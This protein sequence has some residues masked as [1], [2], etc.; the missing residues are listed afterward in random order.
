MCP[1]AERRR[2]E[3][4]PV[5]TQLDGRLVRLE[6]LELGHV[7][8]LVAAAGESRQ[9]YAFSWVPVGADAM[10]AYVEEALATPDHLAFATRQR[11]D[12]RIVG[13]TR[14]HQVTPW[15]W[16]PGHPL[17]RTDR[18]DVVEIGHTWLAASAQR[19]GINSEAKL[20]MLSQAFDVWDVHAVHI[21]TDHRNDRSRRA[22]ERLGATLDGI[23][24]ADRPGADG[25]VRDSALY[26]MTRTEWP[27]AKQR[28]EERIYNRSTM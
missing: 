8:A 15:T 14:Y 7:P 10:R 9:T 28:L 25:T 3:L 2:I 22:I 13:S 1:V 24:R 26:S 4:G 20:L 11:A 17:Q 23:R 5:L 21:S 6:R 27:A 16:P 18:P 12:G 19:T